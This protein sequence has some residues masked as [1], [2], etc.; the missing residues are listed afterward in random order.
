MHFRINKPN[1]RAHGHEQRH[2]QY[3]QRRMRL[4]RVDADRAQ[5][6]YVHASRANYQRAHL[7]EDAL[8]EVNVNQSRVFLGERTEKR[9]ARFL[10]AL[11][12]GNNRFLFLSPQRREQI[13]NQITGGIRHSNLQAF[14]LANQQLRKI[15]FCFF[16]FL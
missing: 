1:H 16:G 15:E 11:V 3:L 8:Q 5:N 2:C 6:K 4:K 14:D 9:Q 12:H 10:D 13:S 7:Q